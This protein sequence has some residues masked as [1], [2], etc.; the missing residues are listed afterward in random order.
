MCGE[1]T[2]ELFD[3]PG[4]LL[5]DSFCFLLHSFRDYNWFWAPWLG[6]H[7]GAIAGALVYL[8]MVGNHLPYLEGS[9][10]M[11]EVDF[12]KDTNIG[13]RIPG[14]ELILASLK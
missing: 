3:M 6:P 9:G 10:D 5:D 13:F 1:E 7:V 2:C 14:T 4:L 12:I 11:Q 8:M